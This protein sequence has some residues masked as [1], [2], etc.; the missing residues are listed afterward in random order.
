ME[1][2]EHHKCSKFLA[3]RKR[4]YKEGWGHVSRGAAAP[5]LLKS[6]GAATY[7][8]N[9]C[10]EKSQG[11]LRERKGVKKVSSTQSFNYLTET[12]RKD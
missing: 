4:S 10:M 9:F 8:G 1:K 6:E 12:L 2:T 5:M 3:G 7:F 11:K